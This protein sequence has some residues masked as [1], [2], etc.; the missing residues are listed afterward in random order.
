MKNYLNIA[1][2]MVVAV[3][4][5]C[6]DRNSVHVYQAPR[7]QAET[8]SP[9]AMT[10]PP[11][12][13]GITAAPVAQ[14][15]APKWTV[16]GT[17]APMPPQPM[18]FATFAV[19]PE[20]SK[21]DVLVYTFGAE[22]G[23]LLEN[24]NRWEGLLGTPPSSEADLPKVAKHF[25]SNGLEIDQADLKGPP[26]AGKT[27]G[28]RHL[29]AIIP[30]NGQVWFVE[31]KGAASKV[32]GHQAE[33]DAFVK[34]ISIPAVASAVQPVGAAAPVVA[35]PSPSN[36]IP[37]LKTY[38]APA[39]WALDP[40]PHQMRLATF[41]VGGGDL[42]A[43][44]IITKFPTGRFGPPELNMNRW[45]GEV[46]L[47]PVDDASVVPHTPISIDG[48]SGF[49]VE[50]SGTDKQL[51][52]AQIAKGDTTYFFKLIGSSATVAQQK[53]AFSEFLQTVRFAD[54]L[55]Q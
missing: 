53:K 9:D 15:T 46:G 19:D 52:V 34:S 43:S 22:S 48:G 41:I 42:A 44:V 25:S 54:D 50:L 37:S 11:D 40:A 35:D 16:P 39:S 30:A 5:G 4:A 3:L 45:R 36:A 55:A 2:I 33:Y 49:T 27:E 26:P 31:L 38:H 23:K 51:M 13:S 20:D 28:L 17:W 29:A 24:V 1:A 7:D 47:D 10:P 14:G 32:T 12:S 8:Q 21:L 6:D 18:S